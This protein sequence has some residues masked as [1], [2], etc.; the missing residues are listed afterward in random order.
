MLDAGHIRFQA[1]RVSGETRICQTIIQ[2]DPHEVTE[3][4]EEMPPLSEEEWRSMQDLIDSMDLSRSIVILSGKQPNGAPADAYASIVARA[5]EQGGR[6]IVDTIGEPLLLAASAGAY[7]VKI[8][9][10]ELCETVGINQVDEAAGE[11]LRSGAKSVLITDG[12]R[13]VLFRDSTR[14]IK[15]APPKVEEIN[16]VGSGDAVTAGVSVSLSLGEPLRDAVI[17]G[18]AC[19]SANAMHPASDML[20]LGDVERLKNQVR[21]LWGGFREPAPAISDRGYRVCLGAIAEGLVR[22]AVP[23][24]QNPH[25]ERCRA[26][27]VSPPPRSRIAAAVF[28]DAL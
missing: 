1:I 22:F 25:G 6:T 18:L 21:A 23:P 17:T 24:A 28:L 12:G 7:L 20:G 13:E 14:S 16:P 11:I 8:N 4:V 3:L 15:L 5:N 19:G 26:G 9:A 2:K 27:S 10:Q